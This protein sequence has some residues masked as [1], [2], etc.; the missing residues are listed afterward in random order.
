MAVSGRVRLLALIHARAADCLLHRVQDRGP[1]LGE[2]VAVNV[3]GRLDPAVSH[4]VGL[5]PSP[6][7]P[8]A[9]PATPRPSYSRSRPHEH[10]RAPARPPRQQHR[11]WPVTRV[12]AHLRRAGW[13]RGMGQLAGTIIRRTTFSWGAFADTV[14]TTHPPLGWTSSVPGATGA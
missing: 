14:S 6:S 2:E 10:W 3:L 8:A 11:P 9:S 4:L 5:P 1:V 13:L 12:G 7:R